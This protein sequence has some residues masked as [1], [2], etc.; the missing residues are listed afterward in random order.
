MSRAKRTRDRQHVRLYAWEIETEAYRSLGCPARA[1]LVEMRAL[2][3][4]QENR[5]YMSRR[6]AQR[7]LGVGRRVAEQAIAELVDRGF[8]R[9]LE[10]GS[11]SRKVR[12]ATVYALTHEPIDDE[13]GP[14]PK[15]YM[16]WRH[17]RNDVVHHEPRRG[18][19]CTTT[20]TV[21]QSKTASRGSPRT[22]SGV[23]SDS[24][25]VRNVPT[26]SLPRGD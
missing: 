11:F 16:R 12:H 1:L 15:D 7:R 6:E 10:E 8:I 13:D 23:N 25:A 2:Y 3:A 24:H 19:P 26:D 20:P 18:T 9:V 5:V 17:P 22:T 21:T 4:G 14:A